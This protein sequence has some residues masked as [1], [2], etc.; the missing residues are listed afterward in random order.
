MMKRLLIAFVAILACTQ[1][2]S[3]AFYPAAPFYP[4]T[5]LSGIAPATPAKTQIK[6]TA[7]VLLHVECFNILATP[8]YVKLFNKTT[9]SVTL[10]TTAADLQFIC[11]GNTAGAGF[12]ANI[13]SPMQFTTAIT[14][15]VT[16]GIA[17][18]DNTSITAASVV[19]NFVYN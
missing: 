1:A 13:S 15:A 10:G 19:V 2:S 6:A 12:V 7:G 18:T 8:V 14:Y 9:A 17:T 5:F 11:P 4:G 16:G 3:Q